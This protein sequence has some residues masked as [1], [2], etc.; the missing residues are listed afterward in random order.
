M[1]AYVKPLDFRIPAA[2]SGRPWRRIVDTALPSPDD[3]V[4]EDQ[5]RTCPCSN[6]IASKPTQ[7]SS[8]SRSKSS[9]SRL[10]AGYILTTVAKPTDRLADRALEVWTQPRPRSPL[11]RRSRSLGWRTGQR[12]RSGCNSPIVR[13]MGGLRVARRSSNDREIDAADCDAT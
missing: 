1:N 8:S 5:G 3:I 13:S 9:A 12:S 6:A 7:P 11:P 4:E 2:P 10:H